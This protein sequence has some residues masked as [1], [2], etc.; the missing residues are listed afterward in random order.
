MIFP[1]I[2]AWTNGWANHRDA[3]DL[4]SHRAH[5]DV[6]VMIIWKILSGEH[7][8]RDWSRS[9]G[10]YGNNTRV[11]SC[12]A[13]GRPENAAR[14]TFPPDNKSRGCCCRNSRPTVINPDYNMTKQRYITRIYDNKRSKSPP[15][16]ATSPTCLH[17]DVTNL[18]LTTG[19]VA[20]HIPSRRV[21]V[22]EEHRQARKTLRPVSAGRMICR[23]QNNL[24]GIINHHKHIWECFVMYKS[25][26]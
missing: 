24:C 11:I 17:C 3:G 4:R 14:G 20:L 19:V 6:T 26:V 5:F 15:N 9:G 21:G 18:S 25:Q 22:R 2:C 13:P 10:R 23:Y 16:R 7:W 1:L 12:P 8:L